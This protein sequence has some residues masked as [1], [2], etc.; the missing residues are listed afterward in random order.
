VDRY[1]GFREFVEARGP[2]LSRSAFLLTGSHHEAEDLLQ[3]ALVKTAAHWSRVARDGNPEAYVRRVMVNERTSRWRRRRRDRPHELID[4]GTPWDEADRT[5]QRLALA[6][7]LSQLPPRQRAAIV[8][9]FYEDRSEAETADLLGVTTGTVKSQVHHALV[10][11]RG[12]LPDQA[13]GKEDVR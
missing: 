13:F 3:A 7:A 5:V 8:L 2:A 10:R 4:V 6:V 9:R 1:Q 11:L 12:L